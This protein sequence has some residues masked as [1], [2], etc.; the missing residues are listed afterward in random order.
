MSTNIG[1]YKVPFQNGD[2]LYLLYELGNILKVRVIEVIN[3]FILNDKPCITIDD[4]VEIQDHEITEIS[5]SRI[6]VK[7]DGIF[8]NLLTKSTADDD[9]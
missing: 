4:N 7:K 9:V 3:L 2:F 5:N 1:P 8:R 6:Q